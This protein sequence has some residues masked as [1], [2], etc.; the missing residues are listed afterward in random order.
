LPFCNN[1]KNPNPAFYK[2]PK[3]PSRYGVLP[4]LL[5]CALTSACGASNAD[6]ISSHCLAFKPANEWEGA[7][8]TRINADCHGFLPFCERVGRIS[9]ARMG[10]R[11]ALQLLCPSAEG[12]RFCSQLHA[13]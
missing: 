3:E 10:Q 12:K 2:T 7:F 9:I 8:G 13:R 4:I 6:I 11:F 5:I 1:A